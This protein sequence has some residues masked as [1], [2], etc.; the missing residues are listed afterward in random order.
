[1]NAA[2]PSP[3]KKRMIAIIVKKPIESSSNGCDIQ[4][5]KDEP[6]SDWSFRANAGVIGNLPAKK[7]FASSTEH[8]ICFEKTSG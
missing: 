1:M 5:S 3:M 6:N 7:S 2:Y 8:P 4:N